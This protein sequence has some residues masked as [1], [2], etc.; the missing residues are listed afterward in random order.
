[1]GEIFCPPCPCKEV[2]HEN[3]KIPYLPRITEQSYEA[4][5]RILQDASPAFEEWQRHL[6]RK[7]LELSVRG[8]GRER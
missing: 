2:T 7:A 1:M 4:C 6:T 8:E 3:S 5:R